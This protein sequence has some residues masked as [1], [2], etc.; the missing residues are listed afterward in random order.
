MGFTRAELESVPR[1]RGPR[2]PPGRRPA[3]AAAVRRHQPG[4]VDRRHA[5]PLRPPRQPVLPRAAA[6]R[7]PH[8]PDRPGSGHDRRG[9]RRA[10]AAGDRHHQRGRASDGTGRRAHASRAA[11]G[12]RAAPALVAERARRRGGRRHHRLPHGVRR[13]RARSASSP[14][15]GRR[16]CSWCPTRRASTPTRPSIAGTRTP[17]AVRRGEASPEATGLIRRS[18]STAP[19]NADVCASTSDRC[20]TARRATCCGTAPAAR[21]G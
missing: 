15:L 19:R 12:R 14:T 1:R 10:P 9:P 7:D 5:V 20:G 18:A 6:R 16:A 4:P 21:R 3:V 13:A 2:P 17:P 8:V 11:G